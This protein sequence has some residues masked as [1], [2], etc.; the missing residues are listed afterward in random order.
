MGRLRRQGAGAPA[1]EAAG[2]AAAEQRAPDAAAEAAA[3][4]AAAEAAAAAAAEAAARFEPTW[5]APSGDCCTYAN[6]QDFETT[7]LELDWLLD[8]DLQEVQ[9][10]ATLRLRVLRPESRV[11]VLD[12]RDLAV[13]DAALLAAPAPLLLRW[14][15]GE[16]DSVLGAPLR[17][18]LPAEGELQEGQ[19][20]T[21]RVSYQ[22]SAQSS[23][24][25]W[26]APELTA[27]GRH[28]VLF[29][30]CQAIHAR[31]LFPC[32]D[33]PAVRAP[34]AAAI[35]SPA[36]LRVLMSALADGAADDAVE[37]VG[38]IAVHRFAQPLPVPAYLVAVVAG[39]FVPRELSP[40]CTV[41]AEAEAIETAAADLAGIEQYL[42]FAEDIAGPYEWGRFDLVC[43]PRAFPY[44][45][46]QAPCLAYL[47]PS[48]L[49][50]DGALTDAVCRE[51]AHAWMG[52]LVGHASWEDCYLSDAFALMLQRKVLGRLRGAVF[53]DFDAILGWD[54]LRADI[55]RLGER[56]AYTAL[57]PSLRGRDPDDAFS[58]VPAEKGFNMLCHV[59]QF[60]GNPRR[61]E[62]WI[63]D[64]VRAFRRQAIGTE[65]MVRHLITYFS[66]PDHPA[67]LSMVDWA[68]WLDA[69]G[70][71]PAIPG[72]DST[73]ADRCSALA[74]RW[75]PLGPDAD[76]ETAR[77]PPGSAADLQGWHSAQVCYFLSQLL[78][79]D[80]PV[81]RQG[82][83]QLEAA[84]GFSGS[85]NSELLFLW[86]R[87]CIRGG[88]DCEQP[89]REYLR[90][91][92]RLSLL[93]PL[94]RDLAARDRRLA[95]ALFD[96]CRGCWHPLCR[97]AIARDLGVTVP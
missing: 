26:L 79:A 19:E 77:T 93:R 78:C 13:H 30:Q 54:Q 80:R 71:P 63:R 84:Y 12:T 15:L 14:D 40:R 44:G 5:R 70:M 42:A 28:P 18:A 34:Y 8:F 90:R 31:S 39:D 32:Q 82:L 89:L 56:H 95:R 59:Q 64:F 7:N 87:L 37:E 6:T 9:G 27:G 3:A 10:S 33:T 48:V 4:E 20:L 73:L 85:K 66:H 21:I 25:C 55:R 1:A 96:D 72:F 65:D 43:M 58:S 17:I 60:V 49:T 29:S 57:R 45:G 11:V 51:V 52:C 16:S 86:L 91:T 38:G 67:D 53:A 22:T 74:Y 62:A 35:A 81:T 97:R 50:G 46:V 24:L 61:F 47:P 36:G 75:L 92:G 69:P 2:A 68:G 23:A 41:W 88:G 76:P 94:F 83:G